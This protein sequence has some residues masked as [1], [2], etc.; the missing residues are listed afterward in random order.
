MAA[1]LSLAALQVTALAATPQVRQ[2]IDESSLIALP[3]T[4]NALVR[5]AQDAGAAEGS[6][7]TG[8]MLLLLKQTPE[9]VE[10]QRELLSQ[11]HD[12]NSS[13]YRKWLTPAQ[14]GE[15]FG[16]SPEDVAAVSGWLALHGL[17]VGPV[18]AARTAIE[19]SG[20]VGQLNAAFH[21]SIHRYLLGGQSH[22]ANASETKIPSALAPVIAGVAG[23]ND[24][25]P[26]TQATIPLHA[27]YRKT[28][29]AATSELA[30]A[31]EGYSLLLGP[32]DAAAVYDTPNSLNPGFHGSHSYT[33][34]GVTIGIISDANIN[35]ADVD[36][37]RS[38]FGLPA[39]SPQVIID[40]GTDPGID[41]PSIG[42]S[43][44][45]LMEIELAGALAPN[46]NVILYTA[47]DTALFSGLT[48]AT[49]RA[50]NDNKADILEFGFRTCEAALAETGNLLVQS[51]WSQAAIQG[52]TVVVAA[53]DSGSAGC[54]L[55]G[56][57]TAAQYGLGVNGY[58]STIYNIAVGGTDFDTLP[59]NPGQYVSAGGTALGYIPE[60]PWNDSVATGGNGELA[61][62]VAFV[63]GS[64]NTNIYAGGGG[65]SSCAYGASAGNTCGPATSGQNSGYAKPQWQQSAV[66]LN[67][68]ADGVRDLPDVALFA[69]DGR[70]GAAWAVCGEDYDAQGNTIADCSAS[71]GS[72]ARVQGLGGTAAAASAFAGILGLVAESQGGRLGQA[73]YVLYSLANQASLYRDIFH[74]LK[75]G[76]N[77]VACTAGTLNCQGNG[78]LSG[79]NAGAGFD[80]ASGLGSVDAT[81]LVTNWGA[82]TFTP[83]TTSLSVTL[84]D[85]SPLPSSVPHGTLLK[86]SITVTASAGTP[87]GLVGLLADVDETSSTYGD[88]WGFKGALDNSGTVSK[89]AADA[90]GG[91]FQIWGRYEGDLTYSASQSAPV[92]LTIT[93][94]NS[95]V[96]LALYTKNAGGA[97]QVTAPNPTYSYG[98]CLAVEA[99]PMSSSST[100]PGGIATG[101]V[102]FADNGATIPTAS[103]NLNNQGFAEIPKYYWSVGSHAITASYAGDN[104]YNPSRST[105]ALVFTIGK[106]VTGM[107]VTAAPS[108]LISGTI[109]VSGTVTPTVS[110]LGAPPTG[111]VTLVDTT[112]GAALG[113]ATLTGTGS[114]GTFTLAVN[115]SLLAQGT[116]T[117]TATYA[118]DGNYSGASAATTAVRSAHIATTLT[119]TA[120]PSS[121][122]SGTFLVSG[123]ITPTSGLA[124]TTP[125]GMVT[126]IDSTSGATLGT[127]VLAASTGVTGNPVAAF[128]LT[129]DASSLVAG[130]NT[131]TASYPGDSDYSGAAGTT[132]VVLNSTSTG[133]SEF[134]ISAA[135]VT[136]ATLGETSDNT[137]TILVTPKNGF[138]GQVNLAV[139]MM[140]GPA[141]AQS[142]PLVKLS[143]PSVMIS[144]S[145]PATVI[146]TITTTTLTY[147]KQAAIDP[148]RGGK[149]Y[150]G[151]A[152]AL[153]CVILLGIPARR[154]GWKAM[155]GLLLIA[156]AGMGM[157]CGVSLNPIATEATTAGNYIFSVTGTD[158]AT[159]TLSA[160]GILTVTVR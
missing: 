87:Q 84:P 91:T 44:Q 35:T 124:G 159:G 154:R 95:V 51:M 114:S 109:T 111:T 31:A 18:N 27:T 71:G 80:L 145:N 9:Q 113:T 106:G 146:A 98:T 54:D 1:F 77:S 133:T 152:A 93:P 78:F 148:S 79:Y 144:G 99:T 29:A 7:A 22:L 41:S 11:L 57:E 86:Y 66:N 123:Q 53:G 160:T 82:A 136:I 116:N 40:G 48:L 32:S 30:S 3:G 83:T 67:I 110:S 100:L 134:D 141:N 88:E 28:K 135:S 43:R 117:L 62:N 52:V 112:N 59:T 126:L 55:A 81:A 61:G 118:G 115:A 21:T 68:P 58:A 137:A 147:G 73:D 142:P 64:G 5:S 10:D 65:A 138:T 158:Q 8:R 12:K 13:N 89:S 4:A 85:G 63:D 143:S 121:L 149:W 60:L 46:A 70:Y 34:A 16:A 14:Y 128:T 72:A 17:Q 33:G 6:L 155:L 36:N 96:N 119:V 157:G 26:G 108:S 94:E 130:A 101:T 19:F 2:P 23:M 105:S 131:L 107:T 120:T 103:N 90:P 37:Y 69:G 139:A 56:T 104:S 42:H 47:K 24:F 156:A 45:A 150:S 74:D 20:T 151:G 25:F 127:A 50:L 75:T 38:F 122:A 153:A 97:Y 102:T 125:S 132:V 49:F 129:I 140:S 76:N 15:R 92:Q 39:R